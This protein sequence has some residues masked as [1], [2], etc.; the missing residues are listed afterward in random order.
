M[1]TES[2]TIVAILKL[3]EKI[4]YPF[5]AKHLFVYIKK[6]KKNHP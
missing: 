4:M 3:F 2:K 5:F 6:E 1:W